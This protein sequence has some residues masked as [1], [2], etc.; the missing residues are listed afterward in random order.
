MSADVINLRRARKAARRDKAELEATEN[1]VAF[2]QNAA[3]RERLQAQ[4]ERGVRH[5]DQHRLTSPHSE[6]P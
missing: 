3:E 4:R 2:G 5:L 6:K 1:R